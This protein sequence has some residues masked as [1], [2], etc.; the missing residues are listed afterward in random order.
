MLSSSSWKGGV[1]GLIEELDLVGED[2]D[3]AADQGCI[4][5]ALGRGH[6]SG[7]RD[8][9]FVSGVFRRSRTWP[10]GRDRRRSAPGLAIAQVDENDAAVVAAAM[11][12]PTDRHGFAQS[13]AVDPAAIIGALPLA[14]QRRA[15]RRRTIGRRPA[16]PRCHS[17]GHAQALRKHAPARHCRTA[18]A[19]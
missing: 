18:V 2:L 5:R 15:C 7:R 10:R 8:D 14:L 11:N 16:R 12:P 4:D 3:L 1:S 19:M 6:A 17:G 13:L 9:E